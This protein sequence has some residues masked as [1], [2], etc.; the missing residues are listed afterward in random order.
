MQLTEVS[1]GRCSGRSPE[2]CSAMPAGP[3]RCCAPAGR[4]RAAASFEL[5]A[6]ACCPVLLRCLDAASDAAA[7]CA[8]KRPPPTRSCG[9]LPR[10]LP[11]SRL[12]CCARRG[13][14][15]RRPRARRV[16]LQLAVQRALPCIFH[17]HPRPL[18]APLA[19]RSPHAPSRSG[20]GPRSS[21]RPRAPL[22][23]THRAHCGLPAL[24]PCRRPIAL[25]ARRVQVRCDA[26]PSQ[27]ST[28]HRRGP[29][30]AGKRAVSV[31]RK[32]WLAGV[33]WTWWH[34]GSQRRAGEGCLAVGHAIDALGAALVAPAALLHLCG[35]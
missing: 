17:L 21:S 28:K 20:I 2:A 8:C 6:A 29:A 13:L 18:P 10:P 30:G 23:R 4:R 16:V 11:A 19:P 22:L 7:R 24:A 5:A 32:R 34:E 9:P 15:L 26:A 25:A 27:G 14:P 3:W 35:R 33:K 1:E 12:P 31:A